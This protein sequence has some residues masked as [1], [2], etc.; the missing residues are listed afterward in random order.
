MIYQRFLMA[1]QLCIKIQ[2]KLIPIIRKPQE[3]FK[4]CKIKNRNKKLLQICHYRLLIEI[5]QAQQ[6]LRMHSSIP[7]IFLEHIRVLSIKVNTLLIIVLQKFYD[8]DCFTKFNFCIFFGE[9]WEI[10]FLNGCMDFFLV[11]G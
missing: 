5:S 11:L 2:T 3:F 7:Q 10:F 8:E 4:T 1:F 6:K 9:V